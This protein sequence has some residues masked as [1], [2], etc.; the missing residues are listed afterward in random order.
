V[1]QSKSSSNHQRSIFNS[2][3]KHTIREEEL[4]CSQTERISSCSFS[5][6]QS[7]SL[8]HDATMSIPLHDEFAF[9]EFN[10]DFSKNCRTNTT[11]CDYEA[12]LHHNERGRTSIPHA[13]LLRDATDIE[14]LSKS[15]TNST[16]TQSFRS[17][18]KAKYSTSSPSL[19][20]GYLDTQVPVRKTSSASSLRKKQRSCLRNRSMSVD[21]TIAPGSLQSS[22]SKSVSFDPKVFV[23]QY[24]KPH[25][26]YTSNGWSKWFV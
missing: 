13:V 1:A 9:Q 10:R 8:S 6:C 3:W 12:I 5:S 21:S 7:P 11:C 23:H 15:T 25:D 22:S 4:S 18:F 24:E 14:T 2:Y 17:L 26:R 16:N 20:Y 19:S